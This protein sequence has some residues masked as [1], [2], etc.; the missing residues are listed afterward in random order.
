MLAPIIALATTSYKEA[1]RSKVLYS[2]IFFVVVLVAVTSL[3]GK[4]TI[5]D[6]YKV[7]KDFG[8]MGISFFSVIFCIITG[9]TMLFKDLSKKTI[10]TIISRPIAR[11]E[12]IVGKF[13][14]LA[15]TATVLIVIMMVL[16]EVYLFLLQGTF[17]F[18][19]LIAFYFIW[20]ELLVVCSVIIFFSSLF[21]TPTVN[22]L[23]ALGVFLAGRSA[24]SILHFGTMSQ[25]K[26]AEY[27]YWIL[28]HLEKFNVINNLVYGEFP[29]FSYGINAGIYCI[30]YCVILIT[31]ATIVFNRRQFN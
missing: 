19:I 18:P 24:D 11:W 23:C 1:V 26:V 25:N 13:L 2:V 5:G 10:Y 12:F 31:I 8:L 15:L 22:G 9:A 28:P 14:G 17:D 16:F 29:S 3:F 21:V 20:L 4:V 27:V 7:S 6:F 30:A